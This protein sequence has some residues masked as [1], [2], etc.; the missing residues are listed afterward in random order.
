[1]NVH[2]RLFLILKRPLSCCGMQGAR[3]AC[4]YPMVG[5]WVAAHIR[6]DVSN[7]DIPVFS[8]CGMLL[9]HSDPREIR[10]FDKSIEHMIGSKKR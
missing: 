7:F 1:M 3:R 9:T 5:W 8:D 6:H 4:M 2:H 10:F